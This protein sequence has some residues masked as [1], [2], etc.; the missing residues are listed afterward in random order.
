MSN[1]SLPFYSK[2]FGTFEKYQIEDWEAKDF[3]ANVLG[4]HL[5]TAENKQKVYQGIGVLVQ[6]GYLKKQ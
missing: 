5:N 3:I 6:C 2:F 4:N 1:R